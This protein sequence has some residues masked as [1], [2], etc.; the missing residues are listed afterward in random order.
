MT[1]SHSSLVCLLEKVGRNFDEEVLKW[2][3]DIASTLDT[4]D[5]IVSVV[6]FLREIKNFFLQESQVSP[7]CIAQETTDELSDDESLDSGSESDVSWQSM[8]PV[9]SDYEDSGS[10]GSS[11]EE[12]PS[13]TCPKCQSPNAPTTGSGSAPTSGGHSAGSKGTNSLVMSVLH[14]MTSCT[15]SVLVG[16]VT[17]FHLCGDNIDHTIKQRYMRV[18][19][20]RQDEIHYFHSYAVCDRIDFSHMSERVVPTLSQDPEQIALSLFPTPE[21]DQAIRKNMCTLMS[22]II[23]ENMDFARLTFD[24][25]VDWHTT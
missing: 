2:K 16:Q 3:N 17:L 22:R 25:V 6:K 14:V 19:K 11:N 5:E 1:V 18:G 10:C 15:T 8:S 20:S 13:D 24:K 21:D 9:T 7:W 23:Y 4:S 12:E